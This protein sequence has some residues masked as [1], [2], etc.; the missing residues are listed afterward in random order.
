[1]DEYTSNVENEV[2]ELREAISELT[3][4]KITLLRELNVEHE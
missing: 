2:K 3:R 4:E 1:L